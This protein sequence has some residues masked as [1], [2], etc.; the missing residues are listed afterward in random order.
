MLPLDDRSLSFHRTDI[1]AAWIVTAVVA[2]LAVC[3]G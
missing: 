3:L 1:F 2:V